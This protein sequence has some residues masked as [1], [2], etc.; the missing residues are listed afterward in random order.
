MLLVKGKE[1]YIMLLLLKINLRVLQ[2]VNME[3][4]TEFQAPTVILN[5]VSSTHSSHNNN[6]KYSIMI[7]DSVTLIRVKVIT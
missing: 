1:K 2:E 5:L 6:H 7:S 4:K 3:A